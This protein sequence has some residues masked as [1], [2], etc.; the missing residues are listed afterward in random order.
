M[1]NTVP[2][3]AAAAAR[4]SLV[5]G[6]AVLL[7]PLP[8]CQLRWLWYLSEGTIYLQLGLALAW[9]RRGFARRFRG[10]DA[11][12]RRGPARLAPESA[13]G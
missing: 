6:P 9:L 1:G 12:G 5:L 2:P 4:V 7:A 11:G 13:T 10:R 8:G 3:L